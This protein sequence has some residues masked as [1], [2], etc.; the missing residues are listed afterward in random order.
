MSPSQDDEYDPTLVPGGDEP[1]SDAKRRSPEGKGDDDF[2]ATYVQGDDDTLV[3]GEPKPMPS[4]SI[5]STFVQDGEPEA[6]LMPDAGDGA[7]IMQ[8]SGGGPA[9]VPARSVPPRRSGEAPVE[10]GLVFAHRFEVV[11]TLGEGGM[12]KVYRVRDR[13]IEGREVALKVLRPL[14]SRNDKFRTLFFKEINAAQ[15]FV[16][17]NVVQVR[18][19]GQMDDGKLFLTMDLVAGESLRSVLDRE[20]SLAVRHALEVARQLLLGLQSGHEQGFVHRDVKPSNVMLA[21]RVPKTEDNPHGVGVRVLDFGIAGLAAEVGE[22]DVAGTP[23]YMSPEQTQ[24]Q[25]LDGRSDLFAVAV[26]FYEMVTGS[27]PFEGDTMQEVTTSVLEDDVSPLIRDIEDLSPPLQRILKKAL[28]KDRDKRFQSAADFIK[29]IENSK[30]YRMPTEMPRWLLAVGMVAV[31]AAAAEGYMLWDRRDSQFDLQNDLNEAR[32]QV[33]M[34]ATDKNQALI[35]QGE[36]FDII[37]RGLDETIADLTQQLNDIAVAESRAESE[38]GDRKIE[39]INWEQWKLEKEALELRLSEAESE[40]EQ[41]QQRVDELEDKNRIDTRRNEDDAR[42]AIGFDEMIRFITRDLGTGAFNVLEELKDDGLLAKSGS[43]GSDYVHRLIESAVALQTYQN[44]ARESENP[45]IAALGTAR[46]KLEAARELERAFL[47]EAEDWLGFHLDDEEP[48]D[49]AALAQQAITHLDEAIAAELTA[50]ESAHQERADAFAAGP[51]DQDP[52]P[53]IAHSQSYGCAH[54]DDLRTRFVA[55]LQSQLERGGSLDIGRLE[56]TQ[57]LAAWGEHLGTLTEDQLTPDDETIL[58]FWS[59][60]RWYVDEAG[61]AATGDPAT[62][63]A[64][65][66]TS[67]GPRDH[68]KTELALQQALA[69]KDSKFPLIAGRRLIYRDED[70]ANNIVTWHI[71]ELEDP[72]PEDEQGPWKINRRMYSEDGTKPITP[73]DFNI[74]RRGMVFSLANRPILDLFNHGLSVK[75]ITWSAPSAVTIPSKSWAPSEEEM[76]D[77]KTELSGQPAPCLI[78]KRGETTR[79]FSPRYGLVLEEEP[80]VFRRELVFVGYVD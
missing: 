59:A 52:G 36:E 43:H 40:R 67:T 32:N 37:K 14:F 53:V 6:T 45:D 28:Q 44:D 78:T 15:N 41:M 30:A 16:S 18:D 23:W 50:I 71:E 58:R 68:W 33:A 54:L 56:K 47:I 19:T 2:D 77:F 12:G 34:A 31:L 22:G 75:T 51:A 35:E 63:A 70:L 27:R 7:T 11:S 42:I 29:A 65:A 66:L 49:R 48:K 73:R 5:D 20:G 64:A 57:V 60:R 80:G 17:E 3:G 26:V 72:I 76:K 38:E 46:T 74:V 24:G 79:W 61:E 9:P 62:L 39:E 25:R 8:S 55:H 1:S 21:A 13:Q 10:D 4:E 69:G